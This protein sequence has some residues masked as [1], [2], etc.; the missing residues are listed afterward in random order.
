MILL[1]WSLINVYDIII[2][3]PILDIFDFYKMVE[4]FLFD[5]I[6]K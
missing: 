2:I 6:S 5:I 3:K 4:F 1:R